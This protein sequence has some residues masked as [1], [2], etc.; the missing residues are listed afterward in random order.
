MKSLGFG[1]YV[2]VAR[3]QSTVMNLHTSSSSSKSEGLD[4]SYHVVDTVKL[5]QLITFLINV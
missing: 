4:S 5:L 1:W 3:D 2:L